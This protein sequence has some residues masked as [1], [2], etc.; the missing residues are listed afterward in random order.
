MK[1]KFPVLNTI[2]GINNVISII[3]MIIGALSILAALVG[4]GNEDILNLI[5]LSIGFLA[6]VIGL[7]VRL[8]VEIAWVFIEIEKN[9]RK[10]SNDVAERVVAPD[11]PKE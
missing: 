6:L 8:W 2:L 5:R 1:N 9:T 7:V 10:E 4:D 11:L 3:L